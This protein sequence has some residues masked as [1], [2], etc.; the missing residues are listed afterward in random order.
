MV[1]LK[2]LYLDIGVIPSLDKKGKGGDRVW[3]E[4][5]RHGYKR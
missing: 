2:R 1:F 4:N 5:R 3:Q